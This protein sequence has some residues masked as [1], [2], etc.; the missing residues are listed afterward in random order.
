MTMSLLRSRR[1]LRAIGATLAC[2][3]WLA[4]AAHAIPIADYNVADLDNQTILTSGNGQLAFTR[5]AFYLSGADPAGFTLSVLGDG[6]RLTGPMS[7]SGGAKAEFYFS[8]EVSVL[9]NGPGI[10]G[11]SLFTPSEITGLSFPTFVKTAKQIY[12]GPTPAFYDQDTLASLL[13]RN[14]DGQYSDFASASFAPQQQ[15]TLLDG[16][17]LAT[18]GAGDTATLAEITNRFSVVPEPA[19]LALL[20]MGVLGLAIAGRRR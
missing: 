10:N 16:V 4:A 14:F 2:S 7:V 3:F 20:G 12:A 13:T 11:V 18:G 17:R 1:T 9:G 5:F 19:T 6:I 8:Y 15:I